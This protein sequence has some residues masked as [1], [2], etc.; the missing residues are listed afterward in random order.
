[1]LYHNLNVLMDLCKIMEVII[2]ALNDV[3]IV[4]L[5]VPKCD[6]V[7]NLRSQVQGKSI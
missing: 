1:M 2:S 7:S 5:K 6:L 3:K 4:N